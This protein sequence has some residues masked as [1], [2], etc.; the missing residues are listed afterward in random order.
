MKHYY[1]LEYE[2]ENAVG[3]SSAPHNREGFNEM[4][5]LAESIKNQKPNIKI[6][7]KSSRNGIVWSLTQNLG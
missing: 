7:I 6:T 5:Y 3:F 4:I 2:T 1:E